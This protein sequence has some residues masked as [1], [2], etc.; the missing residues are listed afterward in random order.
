M[1]VRPS[2]TLL[3]APLLF[4]GRPRAHRVHFFTNSGFCSKVCDMNPLS[5]AHRFDVATFCASSP[6]SCALPAASCAIFFPNLSL[7]ILSSFS[8]LFVAPGLLFKLL[9]LIFASP[10]IRSDSPA[11]GR[12]SVSDSRVVTSFFD[13]RRRLRGFLCAFSIL[14]TKAECLIRRLS[15]LE[16]MKPSS[17][18]AP[19]RCVLS[20]RASSPD[21]DLEIFARTD[22]RFLGTVGALQNTQ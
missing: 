6:L 18:L 5:A 7:S 17:I 10:T 8:L 15:C 2:G 14:F 22:V 4:V 19:S 3:H 11:S 1:L 9:C 20:G 12:A 16:E 21:P 13:G